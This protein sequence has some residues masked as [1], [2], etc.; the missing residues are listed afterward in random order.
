MGGVLW[1]AM[2]Q[3]IDELEVGKGEDH[4]EQ[5]DDQEDRLEQRQEHI[6]EALEAAGAIDGGDLIEL[7]RDRLQPG[8]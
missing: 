7:G 3:H 4:G 1:S 6:A 2:R 5:C 8:E